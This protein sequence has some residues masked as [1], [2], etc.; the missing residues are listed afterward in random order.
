MD[1]PDIAGRLKALRRALSLTQKKMS[2]VLNCSQ[3]K[4]SD[5]ESGKL[6]VSNFDLSTIANT[7]NVNLNWLVTGEGQM[8]KDTRAR[9]EWLERELLRLPVVADIAAGTGIEAFDVEPDEWLTLHPSLLAVP[10]PYLAFKVSGESMAPYILNND[11]AVVTQAWHH[12][13]INERICAVRTIDGLTLKRFMMER[14][15]RCMALIP[16]NPLYPIMQYDEHS[17]DYTVIG[18]LVVVVRKFMGG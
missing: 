10:G 13:D 9:G 12:L 15:K 5:Y 16:L 7:F 1:T 18:L 4:V 17:P 8:F 11:Y 2:E 14:K 6:S 3:A